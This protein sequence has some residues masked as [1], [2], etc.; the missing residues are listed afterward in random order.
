MPVKLVYL[1]SMEA[2][3]YTLI[4]A[5]NRISEEHGPIIQICARTQSDLLSNVN[6]TQLVDEV[7]GADLVIF[8]LMGGKDSLPGFDQVV[9]AARD[10]GVPI[11]VQPATAGN[12]PE[13]WEV[14]TVPEEDYLLLQKYFSYGGTENIA[15][16]LLWLTNHFGGHNFAVREPEMLP[17]EGIYHRQGLNYKAI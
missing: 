16:M 7:R 11:H 17:W 10:Y 12:N 8:H 1:T 5:A 14:S 15:N 9:Q 13:L 2:D 3:I 6:I 4:R